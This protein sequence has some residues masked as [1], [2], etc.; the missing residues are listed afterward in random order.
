MALLSIVRNITGLSEARGV[1]RTLESANLVTANAMKPQGYL[2]MIRQRYRQLGA[3]DSTDAPVMDE[4]AEEE[5][6]E[7]DSPLEEGENLLTELIDMLKVD[8][9]SREQYQHASVT[10][11]LI[12]QVLDAIRDGG[13]LEIR[14]EIMRRCKQTFKMLATEHA[15]RQ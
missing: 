7:R 5:D 8:M 11:S 4:A 9:V 1:M 14:L 13:T 3:A 12:L 2:G 15:N 10:Q 6:E